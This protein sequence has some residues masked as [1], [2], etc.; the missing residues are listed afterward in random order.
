M[1]DRSI[2]YRVA[3]TAAVAMDWSWR[4]LPLRGEPPVSEAAV[5]L[6]GHEM[7]VDDLKAR[8]DLRYAPVIG[9]DE[10]IADL[11]TELAAT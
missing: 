5:A 4:V 8:Q 10:G 3:K 9:V 7:T 6:G 2:P 11:A 1:P